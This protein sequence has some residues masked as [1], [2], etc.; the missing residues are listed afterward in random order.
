MTTTPIPV[1]SRDDVQTDPA[2]SA[3]RHDSRDATL[4]CLLLESLWEIERQVTDALALAQA[5]LGRCEQALE[6]LARTRAMLVSVR[7]AGSP[8]RRPIVAGQHGHDALDHSAHRVDHLTPREAQILHLIT[9]GMS[10]R[11]IADS[12]FVSPRTIERHI[13][14]IYVKID[15]HTKADASAWARRNLPG[16]SPTR[17]P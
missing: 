9:I 1:S 11:L 17:L 5:S 2:P 16:C 14:N 6:Q 15:V 7:S 8:T 12:L 10:N 13:A 3:D 4:A